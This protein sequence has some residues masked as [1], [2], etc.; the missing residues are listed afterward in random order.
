MERRK[1]AKSEKQYL[2][3]MIH[4]LSLQKWTDQDIADYLRDEKSVHI[5]RSTVTKIKNQ[6]SKEAEKWYIELRQS[7]YKYIAT[8][9]ERID[10][11][12][13]YQKKLHDIISNTKKD[14][15]KIRAISELHSIE[16]DLFSLWKQ[17]PDLQIGDSRDNKDEYQYDN[18]GRNGLP[19][20]ISYGPEENDEHDRAVYFGWKQGDPPLDGCFRAMMEQKY[21]LEFEP[22]DELKWVDCPACKR[23]FKSEERLRMHAPI[24]PE[25][26]I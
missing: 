8:Y 13:S 12:L 6:I 16:M 10:S 22:W 21:G 18:V 11:L 5:G 17:L 23:W 15:V 14:E 19:R 24:C 25:P 7:T 3:G 9:K 26:I 1:V 20:A 4:N 2:R